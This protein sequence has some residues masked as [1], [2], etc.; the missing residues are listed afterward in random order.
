MRRRD[1]RE[2]SPEAEEMTDR[3][4]D[5]E[6]RARLRDQLSSTLELGVAAG[7]QDGSVPRVGSE[8]RHE[9]GPGEVHGARQPDGDGD[10]MAGEDAAAEDGENVFEF[11]LFSTSSQSAPKVILASEDDGLNRD[12]AEG[13][14]VADRPLT[15][16]LTGPPG[17]E[18]LAQFDYAAIQYGDILSGSRQRAW[19]LEVPW[20]VRRVIVSSGRTSDKS[21][22]AVAAAATSSMEQGDRKRKRPGKKR[23]I[24]LRQKE[25]ALKEKVAATEKQQMTKEEHL[26]EKKKRLNREKKLKRRQKER[27]KKLTSKEEGERDPAEAVNQT[28]DSEIE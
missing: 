7:G 25:K 6:L 15:F 17:P 13:R 12:G 8:Q 24:A 28:T 4:A 1:L 9:N 11:R 23:R 3:E 26:K 21:G 5:A 27:E 2:S 16:Y 22:R 18:K 20:K 10:D 19:G 14:F